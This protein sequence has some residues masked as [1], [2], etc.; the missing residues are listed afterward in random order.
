MLKLFGN[1]NLFVGGWGGKEEDYEKNGSY[2]DRERRDEDNRAM[3]L[4]ILSF[5]LHINN[6][7]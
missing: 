7:Y 6:F 1:S 5:D 2:K 3:C 4:V